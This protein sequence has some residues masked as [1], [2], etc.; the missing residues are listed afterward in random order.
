M[1][2]FSCHG[3]TVGSQGVEQERNIDVDLQ[4]TLRHRLGHGNHLTC[5]F[6]FLIRS[7]MSFRL[8]KPAPSIR[9][10]RPAQA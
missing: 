6:L 7:Q 9:S 10:L 3:I 2:I 4:S 8:T 1:F 5:G